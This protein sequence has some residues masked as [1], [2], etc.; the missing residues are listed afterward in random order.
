MKQLLTLR[1]FISACSLTA[2]PGQNGTQILDPAKTLE[3]NRPENTD[4]I[5]SSP[6]NGNKGSEGTAGRKFLYNYYL[7]MAQTA[8]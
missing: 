6:K 4:S 7:V 8:E 1:V 5:V 3:K 2:C